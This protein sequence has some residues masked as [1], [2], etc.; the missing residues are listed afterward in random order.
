[1]AKMATMMVA[2]FEET[3]KCIDVQR[4]AQDRRWHCIICPPFRVGW[5]PLALE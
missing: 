3:G 5:A 2:T 1:M 4:N